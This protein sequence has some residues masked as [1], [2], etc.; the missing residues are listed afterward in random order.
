MDE[1]GETSGRGH[2]VPEP[3]ELDGTMSRNSENASLSTK[4]SA[5]TDAKQT[6]SQAGDTHS[7]DGFS[8]EETE[9]LDLNIEA[10]E[11][12][13]RDPY[14]NG[15]DEEILEE[16]SRKRY[17]PWVV[18]GI[19]VA[20][21]AALSFTVWWLFFLKDPPYPLPDA[22]KI[23][24]RQSTEEEGRNNSH[25][26]LKNEIKKWQFSEVN[27]RPNVQAQIQKV[28]QGQPLGNF[29]TGEPSTL[30]IDRKLSLLQT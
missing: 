11:E 25:S 7:F 5:K 6:P 29:S 17:K 30:E 16:V 24:R 22:F 4:D 15:D 2:D 1:K 12:T 26:T 19:L 18:T 10:E 23:L 21:M 8:D 3:S 13:F 28:E 9:A 14:P 27:A 20:V